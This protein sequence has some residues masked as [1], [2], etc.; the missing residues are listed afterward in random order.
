MSLRKKFLIKL[1]RKQGG[2][3]NKKVYSFKVRLKLKEPMDEEELCSMIEWNLHED[4]GHIFTL[5]GR[6]ELLEISVKED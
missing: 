2:T 5:S 1:L 4:F 6:N 3:M